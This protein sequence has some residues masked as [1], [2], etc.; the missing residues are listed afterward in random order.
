M[1][2]KIILIIMN[3]WMVLCN[4][5]WAQE[6]KYPNTPYKEEMTDA[7]WV[8]NIDDTIPFL[9][10]LKDGQID[11]LDE[12][13][14]LAIYDISD[15]I[16]R[17]AHGTRFTP[18]VDDCGLLCGFNLR[19]PPLTPNPYEP[20]SVPNQVYYHDFCPNHPEFRENFRYWIVDRFE[21][22]GARWQSLAGQPITPRNIGYQPDDII[23]FRIVLLGED[24]WFQGN[25]DI[26]HLKD[27]R[28][29]V[30]DESPPFPKLTG[31]YLAV[32]RQWGQIFACVRKWGQIFACCILFFNF[33]S[34]FS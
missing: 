34:A 24:S 9:F 19:C 12:I 17:Y 10:M 3:T 11:P 13:H 7:P 20:E 21:N 26:H 6:P 31:W 18:Q 29:R 32:V 5:T 15:G 16:K 25:N 8:I 23:T 14:C 2:S 22:P 33:S 28:V 30:V 1:L 4:V 27:L